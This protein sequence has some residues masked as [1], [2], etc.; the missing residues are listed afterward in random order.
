MLGD[1]VAGKFLADHVA[2]HVIECHLIHLIHD[3]RVVQL[4]I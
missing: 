4:T 2:R 3:M 1:D